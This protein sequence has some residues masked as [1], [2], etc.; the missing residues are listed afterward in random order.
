MNVTGLWDIPFQTFESLVEFRM[1]NFF[2]PGI[3]SAR[4]LRGI[5]ILFGAIIA[6]AY[7]S[8]LRSFLVTPE[9][10]GTLDTVEV[11]AKISFQWQC[12]IAVI[13]NSSNLHSEKFLCSPQKDQDLICSFRTGKMNIPMM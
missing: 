11:M 2:G 6:M 3:H 13:I 8:L 12:P 1:A 10:D 4:L 9:G 7:A 5:Y